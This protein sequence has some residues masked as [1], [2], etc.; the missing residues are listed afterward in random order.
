MLICIIEFAVIPGM[1][2]R[3]RDLVATL[4]VEAA[5]IEGFMSKETFVSRD[6]E[7][8]VISLSYW[9][10]EAALQAWM[11]DPTHRKIIPLGKSELFSSYTIQIAEVKREKTW[12][13]P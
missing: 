4:L 12:A 3:N 1:E 7:G 8:K 11:R 2:Q 5:K 6:V 13:R 9:R 10:D